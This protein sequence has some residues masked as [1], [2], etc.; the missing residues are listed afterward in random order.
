MGGP[1]RR[2]ALPS[3]VVLAAAAA[4]LLGRPAAAKCPD[5]V[6]FQRWMAEFQ[7]VCN[8]PRNSSVGPFSKASAD[9]AA[10]E[11][12]RFATRDGATDFQIEMSER[13]ARL[14]TICG[15]ATCE[16]VEIAQQV[17]VSLDSVTACYSEGVLRGDFTDDQ[18]RT[19]SELIR[20]NACGEWMSRIGAECGDC[21]RYKEER[22]ACA[23]F[24]VPTI[25]IFIPLAGSRPGSSP[26][27]PLLPLLLTLLAAAVAPPRV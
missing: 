19:V 20:S 8:P 27:A 15:W 1:P 18:R 12:V 3:L 7:V 4:L 17:P 9:L 5:R 26:F 10:K 24:T 6:R 11:A 21:D 16:C 14:A 13:M 2:L 22:P 25:R 23:N